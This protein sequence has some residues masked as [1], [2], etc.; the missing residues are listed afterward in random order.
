ML[1]SFDPF[2]SF[3]FWLLKVAVEYACLS[4]FR[5]E[6]LGILLQGIRL[7]PLTIEELKQT[8]QIPLHLIQNFLLCKQYELLSMI[9]P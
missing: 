9:D 2:L 7:K 3:F 6:N 5:I 4:E 8:N 1:L